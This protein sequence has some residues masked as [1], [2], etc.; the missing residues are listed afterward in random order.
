MN[1]HQASIIDQFTRQAVPF[2][3]RPGHTNEQSLRLLMDAVNLGS[4]DTVLDVACGPGIVACAFAAIANHVTGIDITPA[5]LEQAKLLQKQ[6]GL[7]NLTWQHGHIETLPFADASFS[8]VL[9]RY[10]FHHFLKPDLVLS[11][12]I[13]VCRPGG[14]I[15]IADVALPPDKVD[16]FNK[17]E[18][19]RD[20]S[21]TRALTLEEL[22][23]LIAN[24]NLQNIGLEFYKV[25]MELEQQLAASFPNPGD[26]EKIRQIFRDDLGVDRLGVAAHWRDS[27]IYYA[28]PITV[29]AAEKAV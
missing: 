13:R 11:E 10:A 24:T 19:L 8:V 9:S 28:Y 14:R 7:T 16:A 21:H 22:Q 26:D 18:K 23:S 27:A 3:Q 2:S 29:I 4:D 15:L 25:E 6:R 1:R 17:F 5:M 20:P 12:M